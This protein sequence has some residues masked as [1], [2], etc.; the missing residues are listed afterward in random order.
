MAKYITRSGK[1][2]RSDDDEDDDGNGNGNG[3][4]DND[5]G[6]PEKN[7]SE[8]GGNTDG[9]VGVRPDAALSSSSTLN[10]SSEHADQLVIPDDFPTL[11]QLETILTY[12]QSYRPENDDDCDRNNK[13]NKDL[14]RRRDTTVEAVEKII[15][16]AE[17]GDFVDDD[18]TKI[19]SFCTSFFQ[20]GGL[21]RMTMFIELNMKDIDF[22]DLAVWVL[23][24]IM[25]NGILVDDEDN[26][27]KLVE[28]SCHAFFESPC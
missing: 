17:G 8:D 9:T 21:P 25:T 16:W 7:D 24:T 4:G 2:K 3:E 5:V 27:K 11:F 10:R 1:R 23:Y 18:E 15:F 14:T 26:L 12:I 6:N 20:L 19:R 13:H 28:S 22:V